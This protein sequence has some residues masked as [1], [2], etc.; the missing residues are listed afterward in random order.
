MCARNDEDV[1]LGCWING[2]DDKSSFI[3]RA[4]IDLR[5]CRVFASNDGTKLAFFVKDAFVQEPKNLEHH[6]FL[7]AKEPSRLED[8]IEDKVAGL[9]LLLCWSWHVLLNQS[10]VGRC[11]RAAELAFKVVTKFLIT[12]PVRIPNSF[13]L[14]SGGGTRG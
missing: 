11:H 4:V 5:G 8:K 7:I 9:A 1:I 12:F 14:R 6:P 2:L 3:P 13:C 10:S